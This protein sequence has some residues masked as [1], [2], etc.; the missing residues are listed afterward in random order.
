MLTK[1]GAP[2]IS[3]TQ[4]VLLI[5]DASCGLIAPDDGGYELAMNSKFCGTVTPMPFRP[6]FCSA[7]GHW[8]Q[9]GPICCYK[10]HCSMTPVARCRHIS[11]RYFG[12]KVESW[13]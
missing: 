4:Q 12:H 6:A 2:M 5:M 10:Y 3:A 1:N 11:S 13:L 7:A 9:R 8:K